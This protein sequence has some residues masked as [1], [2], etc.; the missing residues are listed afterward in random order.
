[1]F[2]YT[3]FLP[4]AS[5]KSYFA[6]IN[7]CR[8]QL[9]KVIQKTNEYRSDKNEHRLSREEIENGQRLLK[10]DA[11]ENAQVMS[12]L[13]PEKEI[14]L[15]QLERKYLPEHQKIDELATPSK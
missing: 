8:K 5:S 6:S 14:S 1:M 4:L 11:S 3:T 2:Q 10:I 13:G 7:D 12:V 15:V 9:I